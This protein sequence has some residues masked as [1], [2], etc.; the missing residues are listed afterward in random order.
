MGDYVLRFVDGIPSPAPA[1]RLDLNDGRGFSAM[2]GIEAPPPRLRRSLSS[3]AL[4]DGADVSASA[5]ENRV[6]TLKL[7]V[8]GGTQDGVARLLHRLGRELN[9]ERNILEFCAGQSRSVYFRTF[10][11]VYDYAVKGPETTH[12]EI[13]VEVVAEPF[14]YAP[15]VDQAPVTV[16]ND[17]HAS[18]NAMFLDVGGV[19]GDVETPGYFTIEPSPSAYASLMLASRRRGQPGNVTWFR[20]AETFASWTDTAIVNTDWVMSSN[21]PHPELEGIGFDISFDMAFPPAPPPPLN[22]QRT[23]F[24]T[25]DEA[26]RLY[27]DDPLGPASPDLRG[28][29]RLFVVVKTPDASGAPTFRLRGTWAGPNGASSGAGAVDGR[30][31]DISP[32]TSGRHVIDLGLFDVP[33][34]HA[35]EAEGY[36]AHS[37]PASSGRLWLKAGRLSGTGL[38]DWD[39]VM[40]APADDS[41]GFFEE[42]GG[43]LG[44]EGAFVLDGPNNVAYTRRSGNVAAHP[45]RR[46]G[47]I[48]MLSPGVT[49]RILVARPDRFGVV[50]NH[51]DV[52]TA[53]SRIAVSYWPRHLYV[54]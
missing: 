35:P 11:S 45:L 22:A 48:P 41:L 32:T 19:R 51:P 43:H 21:P 5:Y 14:A 27:F 23:T 54:R 50:A 25:A 39:Y 20:Q 37:A 6:L 33:S 4:S 15:R 12:R 1:L 9:R 36:G 30:H 47:A 44:S 28:T 42:T 24:I 10:R 2:Q 13:T 40:M 18:A 8:D 7:F 34:A 38:L 31:V 53:S 26:P 3:N 46:M 49:N 52:K 16:T 17:P 29:Y